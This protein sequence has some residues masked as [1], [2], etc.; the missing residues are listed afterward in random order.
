MTSTP[1]SPGNA[2]TRDG[3]GA[4]TGML[5]CQKGILNSSMIINNVG[6]S[7]ALPAGS[8]R[9]A[10][11]ESSYDDETGIRCTGELLENDDIA[12]ARRIGTTTFTP[13]DYRK[14]GKERYEQVLKASR[15]FEPQI[16]YF[17]GDDF[18]P[19]TP[20]KRAGSCRDCRRNPPVVDGTTCRNCILA[21]EALEAFWDVI[22]RHFPEAKFGDLSF[23]QTMALHDE[24]SPAIREW[25]SN[26]VE[27]EGD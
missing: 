23:E 17:G 8:Y 22:V 15:N 20:D 6:G 26:N 24:A 9:V 25:I 11:I 27:T 3:S 2:V 4:T 7:T 12:L 13:E 19:D 18:V 21:D 16:V 1:P 5:Y 10:L 14:Y